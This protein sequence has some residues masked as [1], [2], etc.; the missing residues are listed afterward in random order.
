MELLNDFPLGLF[1]SQTAIF[2]LLVFLLKKYAWKPILNAVEER[3]E[4]IKS[5]L[6]SAESAKTEMANIAADN[7]RILKEARVEREGILK[8]AKS[9][10]DAIINEAKEEA[11]VQADKII[12]QA[13]EAMETEKAAAISV[14]KAQVAE[15]SISIAEKVVA[16]ELSTDKD[17]LALVED[18]LKDVTLN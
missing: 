15:L 8:D 6:E 9:M 1:I 18:K 16:K 10:K 17:Q 11:Q 2:I 14:L 3:E 4:G 5:A 12:K 7:E 13:K